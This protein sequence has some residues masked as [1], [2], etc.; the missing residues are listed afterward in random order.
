MIIIVR[1]II[2]ALKPFTLK[3]FRYIR[4]HK[5]LIDKKPDNMNILEMKEKIEN[6]AFENHH[7]GSLFK[8]L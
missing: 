2:G 1:S 8:N 3:N 5:K 4:N 6:V 7:I